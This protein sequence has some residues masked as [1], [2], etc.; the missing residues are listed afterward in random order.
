MACFDTAH[1]EI[2]AYFRPGLVYFRLGLVYFRLWLEL[3]RGTPTRNSNALGT[4][5]SNAERGARTRN[6]ERG[7]RQKP[8]ANSSEE[9]ASI[10]SWVAWQAG[11]SQSEVGQLGTRKQPGSN[12]KATRKQP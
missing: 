12:Q 2:L 5:N 9:E 6:A 1:I 8:F 4:R 3:Q 10:T 11:Q 7:D